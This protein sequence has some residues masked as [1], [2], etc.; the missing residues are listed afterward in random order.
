MYKLVLQ[1]FVGITLKESIRSF[2]LS[3]FS[4]DKTSIF[5]NTIQ[6]ED[7]KSLSRRIEVDLDD[8]KK[9]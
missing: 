4:E 1:Q 2:N 9:I 8:F 5:P 3:I 6:I 7:Y